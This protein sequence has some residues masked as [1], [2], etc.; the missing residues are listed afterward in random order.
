MEQDQPT[1][2]AAGPPIIHVKHDGT[3]PGSPFRPGQQ[4]NDFLPG[5]APLEGELVVAKTVHSAFHRHR[6]R[7]QPPGN[8][9]GDGDRPSLVICGVLLA[10]SIE[11]TVRVAGNLGFE[12]RLPGDACWSCDKRD[13]TCRL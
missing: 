8:G 1:G 7:G 9:R 5:T 10:N 13:L 2:V 4:G 6:P 12:V 3:K 11:A